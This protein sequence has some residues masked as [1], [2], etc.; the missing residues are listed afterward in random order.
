M[1][2]EISL[3]DQEYERFVRTFQDSKSKAYGEF[4]MNAI[5]YIDRL[6]FAKEKVGASRNLAVLVVRNPKNNNEH[7]LEKY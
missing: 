3:T 2:I 4:V 5:D 6:R 7:I 1:K